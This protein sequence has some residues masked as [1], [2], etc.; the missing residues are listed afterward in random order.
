MWYRMRFLES[1]YL[2][3][4]LEYEWVYSW[5][6]IYDF[7]KYRKEFYEDDFIINGRND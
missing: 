7:L 3:I 5:D 4:D 6:W 2:Y 1:R